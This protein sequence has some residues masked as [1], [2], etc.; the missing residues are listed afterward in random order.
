MQG[1]H[2][3]GHPETRG[4]GAGRVRR[5]MRVAVRREARNE[6]EKAREPGRGSKFLVA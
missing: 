3:Q 6:G 4:D 2:R 1:Q 5:E